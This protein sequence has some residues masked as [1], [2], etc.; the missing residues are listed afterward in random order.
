MVA[1]AR[2]PSRAPVVA[3]WGSTPR[4]FPWVLGLCSGGFLASRAGVRARRWLFPRPNHLPRLDNSSL[5]GRNHGGGAG[6][7]GWVLA[8]AGCR[9]VTEGCRSARAET[10]CFELAGRRPSGSPPNASSARLS[11]SF[12]HTCP[13]ACLSSPA[14]G[15]GTPLFSSR[16]TGFA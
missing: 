2:G 3:R 14:F 10:Y 8:E 1:P 11:S 6:I 7:E 15:V 4:F 9:R 12:R 5:G 13:L 16:L